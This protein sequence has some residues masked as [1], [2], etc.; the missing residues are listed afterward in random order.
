VLKDCNHDP[1]EGTAICAT[2]PMP[3]DWNIHARCLDHDP[4]IFF[5]EADDRVLINQATKI[6]MSCPVRGFCLEAGWNDKFGIWGSFTAQERERLKKVFPLPKNTK[7][8]RRIV[9]IIAH[10][11]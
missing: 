8:K 2:C 11:L 9:R 3:D 10:R 7:D 6:C 4:E 1:I 5:P